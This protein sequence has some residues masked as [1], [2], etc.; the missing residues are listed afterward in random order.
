MCAHKQ[1]AAS[2]PTLCGWAQGMRGWVL[3]SVCVCAWQVCVGMYRHFDC[4]VQPALGGGK[5]CMTVKPVVL[6]R[7]PGAQE[8]HSCHAKEAYRGIR[9]EEELPPLPCNWDLRCGFAAT[10]LGL[11]KDLSS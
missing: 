7:W 5:C 9:G 10:V 1:D 11:T 2:Q 8:A 3:N 6:P 4:E